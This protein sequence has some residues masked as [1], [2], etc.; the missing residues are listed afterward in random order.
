M[1]RFGQVRLGVCAEYRA[2]CVRCGRDGTEAC[3]AFESVDAVDVVCV[4]DSGTDEAAEELGEEVDW[5]ASP[6]KFTEE[7]V[8]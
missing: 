5:E 1:G 4:D 8:C 7:A 6:G 2:C 3:T